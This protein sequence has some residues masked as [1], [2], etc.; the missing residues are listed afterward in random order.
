MTDGIQASPPSI[1][2][3]TAPT[4]HDIAAEWWVNNGRSANDKPS[5]IDGEDDAQI[6][7]RVRKMA[8]FH[9]LFK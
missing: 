6:D 2:G 8:T 9:A 1:H 4:Q 3:I 7:A 5:I